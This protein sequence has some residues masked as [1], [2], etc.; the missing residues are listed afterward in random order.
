MANEIYS[1]EFLEAYAEILV[2]CWADEDFKKRFMQDPAGV[3]KEWDIEIAE[4][5]K[6]EVVEVSDAGTVTISLPPKPTGFD[7][8]SDEDLDAV[9]GGLFN[10]N[11]NV[12][13]TDGD[14]THPVTIKVPCK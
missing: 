10:I 9:A 13:G 11:F 1:E 8:L 7:E 6:V 5:G 2:E 3:L 12:G 14:G 4:D